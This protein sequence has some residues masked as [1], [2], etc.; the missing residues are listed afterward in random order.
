MRAPI[1]RLRGQKRS[2]DL[3]IGTSYRQLERRHG[4][5]LRGRVVEA[6]GRGVKCADGASVEAAAVVWATGFRPDY[7]WIDLPVLDDRGIPVHKRGVT[8]VPGLYFLG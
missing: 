1:G 4:V 5:T 6:D 3:L 2:G 7:S 8:E